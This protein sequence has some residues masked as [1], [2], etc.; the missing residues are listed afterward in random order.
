ML[1]DSINTVAVDNGGELTIDRQG[2]RDQL[3]SVEWVRGSHRDSLLRRFRRLRC[4]Q[5]HGGEKNAADQVTQW[6]RILPNVVFEF[7]GAVG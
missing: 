5:D 4:D 3:N 2:L 7:E 6:P 1:L